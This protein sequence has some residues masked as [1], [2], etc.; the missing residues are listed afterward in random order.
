MIRSGALECLLINNGN[1]QLLDELAGGQLADAF[2][3]SRTLTELVLD[4]VLFWDDAAAAASIVRALTGHPSLE[5]LNLS[6]NSPPEDGVAGA[7]ALLGQLVAANAPALKELSVKASHLGD[8]GLRPAFQALPR[9][10]HLRKLD[11]WSTGSSRQF[12]RDVVLPAVRVNT[13]LRTLT[14][15]NPGTDAPALDEAAELVDARSFEADE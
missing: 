12:A 9:N 10:T 6:F 8:E 7:A 13:S 15:N 14:A 11:C 2:A 4:E 3:T 1:T 5:S